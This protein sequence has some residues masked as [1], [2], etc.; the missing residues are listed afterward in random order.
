MLFSRQ[1]GKTDKAR[2]MTQL[3]DAGGRL[4]GVRVLIVEDEYY[5]ADDFRRTLS[6]AGA[7]VIA[8]CASVRAAQKAIEDGNFD[9]AVLD[10][11]LNG[12]SGEPLAGALDARGIP[13]AI[14]TGYGPSALSEGLTAV[15]WI[16]K[17]FEPS[18]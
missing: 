15:P 4:R 12:E 13:Y 9:V 14:A 16:E 10:L 6:A 1:A 3:L 11:N 18:L 2:P 8:S 5:I 7:S 17:P